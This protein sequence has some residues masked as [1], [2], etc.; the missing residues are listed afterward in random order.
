MPFE[1]DRSVKMS[2]HTIKRAA[3]AVLLLTS[4]ACSGGGGNATPAA[5]PEGETA[6]SCASVIYAAQRLVSDDEVTDPNDVIASG[7][8]AALTAYGTVHANAEGLNSNEV[9]G[10]VKVNAMRMLGDIPGGEIISNKKIVD[11]AVKC[12]G[13]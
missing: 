11:R 6:L 4:A 2:F 13:S 12:I 3:A 9:L 1:M 10:I 7:Y 8:L 5:L